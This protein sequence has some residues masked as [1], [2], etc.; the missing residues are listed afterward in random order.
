[1]LQV[2]PQGTG[3]PTPSGAPRARLSPPEARILP[4][5]YGQACNYLGAPTWLGG[6]MQIAARTVDPLSHDGESEVRILIYMRA[7]ESPTVVSYEQA[8]PGPI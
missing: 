4:L 7:L 8:Y 5:N 6:N 1:V 2:L 3:A